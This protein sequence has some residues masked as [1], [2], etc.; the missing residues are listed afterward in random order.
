MHKIFKGVGIAIITVIII[1]FLFLSIVYVA[2]IR[3][4]DGGKWQKHSFPEYVFKDKQTRQ[5]F[6][7]W[8][9]QV[10][11]PIDIPMMDFDVCYL[12]W[13]DTIWDRTYRNVADTFNLRLHTHRVITN[14]FR[15]EEY[16]SRIKGV[17]K[18][19]MHWLYLY[20]DITIDRFFTP[21]G[22]NREIRSISKDNH[23]FLQCY[24]DEK[25]YLAQASEHIRPVETNNRIFFE[26]YAFFFET[27]DFTDY[28]LLHD[29]VERDSF[30]FRSCG[31]YFVLSK[32]DTLSMKETNENF[33]HWVMENISASLLDSV[34]KDSRV[35]FACRVDTLGKIVD[36]VNYS[37]KDLKD[38]ASR[39]ST[40]L[41]D[42]V[43]AMERGRT[44]NSELGLHCFPYHYI[45]Q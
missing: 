42:L 40:L 38:E 4:L 31:P 9:K 45:K 25:V 18:F 17:C 14:H 41:P 32:T 2:N 13:N 34:S 24:D 36:I 10:S 33:E 12:P 21:K 5:E 26:G 37:S 3:E 20:D 6:E 1:V 27:A 19:N 30:F 35:S 22:R 7:N 39:L 43:P 11:L 44:V 8:M 29:V 23:I 15:T 16:Y 28:A